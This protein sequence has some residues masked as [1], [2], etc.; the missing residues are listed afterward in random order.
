M[1]TK[2]LISATLLIFSLFSL[3]CTQPLS[4]ENGHTVR[5]DFRFGSRYYSLCSNE[6]GKSYAI[7]GF[8]S[9]YDQPF[10]VLSSD[11]SAF[12]ILDSA[13]VFFEKLNKI[14][15]GSLAVD[16]DAGQWIGTCFQ[17]IE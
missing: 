15:S 2:Y 17:R 9:D 7:R 11:T 13:K 10:N 16:R 8:C 6:A 3:A 12:F 1:K 4:K 5:T 14:R